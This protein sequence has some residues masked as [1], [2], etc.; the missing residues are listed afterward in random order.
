MVCDKP[1][2]TH[3]RGQ[4]RKLIL[5]ESLIFSGAYMCI[6]FYLTSQL[7]ACIEEYIPILF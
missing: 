7:N 4:L 6:W 3:I 5:I 2:D 1:W